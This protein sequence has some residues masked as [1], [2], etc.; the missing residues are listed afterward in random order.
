MQGATMGAV[1]PGILPMLG[2]TFVK[3]AQPERLRLTLHDA[4]EMALKQNPQVQVANLSVAVA[5]EDQTIARSALLP[6]ASL[7]VSEAV[8]RENLEAFL[9]RKVAGFPVPSGPFWLFQGGSNGS[10]PL[11]D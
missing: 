5:Q 10:V 4:V 6:Q 8:Q 9:G 3:G 1:L 11:L 2:A 7:A